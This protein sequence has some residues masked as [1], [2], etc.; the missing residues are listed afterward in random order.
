MAGFCGEIK[1][2]DAYHGSSVTTHLRSGGREDWL[3]DCSYQIQANI[4]LWLIVIP[5]NRHWENG[6]QAPYIYGLTDIN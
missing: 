1:D 3:I 4:P 5:P 2:G 6:K